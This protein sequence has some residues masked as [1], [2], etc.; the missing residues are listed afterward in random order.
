MSIAKTNTLTIRT[1]EGI[2]FSLLLAGPISRF[3]AWSVDLLAIL[4]I[5]KLLNVVF[6]AAGIISQDLAAAAHI[7]GYFVVS[8]GYGI[9]L[10]WYWHGQTLG[11]RMMRL[12]VTDV[13]GLQLHFSQ[14]VI[15]NLLRFVDS[16]PALYLVGGLACLINRHG[17]RLGDF[18][19]NT[20]VVWSPRLDEP[21]L[22]Q[23]LEGKY[24]SF[25]KYPHLEARLRQH[26]SPAESRIALQTLVRRDE[27]KPA[28]R[29]ELFESLV[30]HFKSIVTFP[31][32]ATDGISDEQYI[33]NV[34]DALFRPKTFFVDNTVQ[35]H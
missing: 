1:P 18:A 24:N 29:V 15:R 20:I 2:E 11:K 26:V 21:D 27:I 4:A 5:N 7:L 19:A 3:L 6:G 17:Q 25:R 30:S 35:N 23:L 22:D 16:L 31:P 33:R 12:R 28:A 14:V 13:H 32:E 8:I 10:E 9:F 34:V